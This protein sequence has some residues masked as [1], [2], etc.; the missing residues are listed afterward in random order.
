MITVLIADDHDIVREGVKQIVSETSDIVV[1]GEARSGAEALDLARGGGWD[2][3]ILDLNLPDRP[4]LD[5]LA[6]LRGIAPVLILSMH[7]EASYASRA[8]RS[9]ALGYVSKSSAR[10]DLVPA[11][12]NV[13]RGERFLTPALAQLLAFDAMWPSQE[14][15]HENLSGREFQIL[16]LIAAGK[17]PRDIAAELNVSVKTVATHRARLLQKMGL[18]NNAEL[19][20][21]AI[22]HHLLPDSGR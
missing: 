8:L 13:A 5:V 11:I 19:V 22:E 21:Y 4:G 1:G 15:S 16:C 17:P 14:R 12:R 7:A 3:I 2:V 18:R 9:G 6:Q 20:Q 10:E